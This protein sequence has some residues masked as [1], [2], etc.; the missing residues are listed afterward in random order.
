VSSSLPLEEF[1]ELSRDRERLPR[2]VA[3]VM[4]GNGR[5]ARQR[6]LARSEGHRRGKDSVRAVVD[7]ALEFGIP[8]LT[9]F[10]FS[11]ENWH[12]PGSEVRFLM[13]LVHRYLMTE[14]KRLMKRGI[15]LVAVGQTSRLP[16]E[17]RR[18]LDD[19]IAAT[20]GNSRMTIALAL[21]YG[22]RQDIIGAIRQIAQSVTDGEL[23]IDQ[24][25][26]A[27]LRNHLATAGL[28][29]PDLL[30]R[31]SGEQRISNFFLYE[32][33]YTELYFTETLWPDFREREFMQALSAYQ[34]RERR[35]GALNGNSA[36]HRLRAAN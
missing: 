18:V 7:T 16:A 32:L 11:N 17:V 4:D 8:Y 21:S 10:V 24:I 34:A 30:I 2:H 20:V 27:L 23:S 5:W 9:L 6:G 29:D 25:D 22:G 14:T 31:T 26:E 13:Q 35:F 12:R 33:A 36:S 3:I 15:R 28:P 19:A 1:P